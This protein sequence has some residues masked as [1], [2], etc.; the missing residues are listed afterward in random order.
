[1]PTPHPLLYTL[2]GVLLL[3]SSPARAD[4]ALWRDAPAIPADPSARGSDLPASARRVVLVGDA[5][6]A[7][8]KRMRKSATPSS[9]ELPLPSG[10]TSE[11]R[12]ESSGVLP[13]GLAARYPELKSMKGEDAEGRHV[14]IDIGPNGISAAVTDAGGDWLLRPETPEASKA[15]SVDRRHAVFR[16]AA[17]R[18]RPYREEPGPHDA[19][20]R[21]GE[22]RSAAGPAMSTV[23]RTFRIALTA[24]PSYTQ[25]QGGTRA[26]TLQSMAATINR[27]NRI[28]ERDFGVHL[29]LAEDSDKLIFTKEGPDPFGDLT[30]DDRFYDAKL[31]ERNVEVVAQVLADDAFDIGHALDARQ[32]A[33]LVGEIGNTCMRWTGKPEDRAR[34][35]AAGMTG[36][37]RPF[38]DPF[39]VD[40]VAH[41]LGHQFGAHHTF[42]GC[43]RF[44]ESSGVELE[45]GSGSTVMGYAG[46]C[47]GHNLQDNADDYFH[48]A[49]IQEV[50]AWL[51]GEGG[52]CAA[53]E[54]NR[55]RAPWLDTEGWRQPM[56]VPAHTPF[57]LSGIARFAAPGA[58]PSYTFEQMDPGKPQDET[59]LSDRGTGPLFRSRKP[60]AQGEQTFPA[61]PVLLGDEKLGLGDALPTRHR[62]LRFRMTVRDEREDRP[63]P[64]VSAERVVTVIDTGRPF[65]ITAPNASA[66]LQRGKRRVVRWNVAGTVKAPIACRSVRI[67]LSVDGGRTFLETPL[68]SAAPNQGRATVE[69]PAGIDASQAA[70]LRVA[71]ADGRFFALSPS[72]RV[73]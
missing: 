7:V 14:R 50:A 22:Q 6:E 12:L 61:M 68:A 67:D 5:F 17:A 25:S 41:E 2:P 9:I 19:A 51:S 60:N 63:S 44:S 49:S 69:I 4:Q 43:G 71:C 13:P 31:V 70:R 30:T 10:G 8:A 56:L 47:Y 39:H 29:V 38:G 66:I 52:A 33:G 40:F 55:S 27:V 34:S 36:S 46:L 32:D 37:T 28:F 35:K 21:P 59:T 54:A 42:N 45:P 58:K 16:R 26:Q 62:D 53:S 11:F 57:R 3:A 18:K 73:R 20:A 15:R 64:V 72:I 1:M 23:R 65:A 48:G 24:T